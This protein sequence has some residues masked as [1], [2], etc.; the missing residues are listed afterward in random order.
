MFL[1]LWLELAGVG[2][3]EILADTVWDTPGVFWG[4]IGN[5]LGALKSA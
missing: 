1:Q 4:Y 3:A 5:L 2:Y